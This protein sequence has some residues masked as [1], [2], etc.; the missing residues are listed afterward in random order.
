MIYEYIC[1]ICH[2]EFCVVEENLPKPNP[3]CPNCGSNKILRKVADPN[4]DIKRDGFNSMDKKDEG[5]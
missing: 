3:L 2:K 4:D 5:S 1:A